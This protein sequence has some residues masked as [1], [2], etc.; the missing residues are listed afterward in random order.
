[1]TIDTAIDILTERRACMEC[2]MGNGSCEDCDNAFD[3][4]IKS[5]GERK[6]MTHEEAVGFLQESGWL[7]DHDKQIYEQGKRDSIEERKKGKWIFGET[8]GHSWMKCSECCKSQDGQTL[9]FTY[10]PNCGAKMEGA[11]E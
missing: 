1:M 9:C 5:L 2:V 3:M 7:Q 11:E 10:C 6:T 8:M 4:A